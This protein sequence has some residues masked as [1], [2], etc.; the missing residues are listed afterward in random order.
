MCNCRSSEQSSRRTCRPL[1]RTARCSAQNQLLGFHRGLLRSGATRGHAASGRD[2]HPR[3]SGSETCR[4]SRPLRSARRFARGQPRGAG[5][6]SSCP[7]RRPRSLSIAG[8]SSDVPRPAS[9]GQIR[10][11]R[12][13]SCLGV[14]HGNLLLGETNAFRPRRFR[15]SHVPLF[16]RRR[17]DITGSRAG[18]RIA[19]NRSSSSHFQPPYELLRCFA[20]SR[21]AGAQ[22]STPTANAISSRFCM[23]SCPNRVYIVLYCDRSVAVD[24][25]DLDGNRF[26]RVAGSLTRILGLSVNPVVLRLAST[27]GSRFCFTRC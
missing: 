9:R 27:R 23:L 26:L 2:F 1:H 12:T 24:T 20:P 13:D 14:F 15:S 17:T 18:R 19:P 21:I 7:E 5:S 22:Q 11:A 6:P 3:R 4:R 25:A 8:Q 16:L 10:R